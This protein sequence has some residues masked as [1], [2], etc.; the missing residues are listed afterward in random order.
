MRGRAQD[1]WEEWVR[2]EGV[3]EMWRE[4]GRRRGVGRMAGGGG[5]KRN[6]EEKG[7]WD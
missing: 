3:G 4:L 7:G 1:E 6:G 2:L 5:S